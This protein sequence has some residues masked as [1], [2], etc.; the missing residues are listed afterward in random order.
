MRKGIIG[1]MVTV[2]VVMLIVGAVWVKSAEAQPVVL[3]FATVEPPKSFN[4]QKVWGPI[5]EK[6]NKEAEGVFKIEIFA[7]GTLGRNPM[8][9]MK[10]L[11]D[12]VT[13]L[14][15][16]INAYLPGQ[17]V[18]DQV[19]NTPFMAKNCLDCTMS[20]HYM[21]EK[22]MLRGYDD[23]VILG[24]ICL[25]Q[26][27]IHTKFPVKVPAD[28]KGKKMRTAGKI[29]HALAN[30]CGA[31]PVAMPITKVAE[32]ISRGVI[33]GTFSD[34]NAM[35]TFRINDVATYHCLVPF[36]STTLMVAMTKKK[37]ESLP[38]KGKAVIDKY[39]GGYFSRYW[40]ETLDEH[41]VSIETKTTKDPKHTVYKPNAEEMKQWQAVMDPV[42]SSW[43]NEHDNWDNLLKAY[44]DGLGK[45]NSLK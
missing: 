13:D 34:W 35:Q 22:K 32:S 40:A 30:A 38:P 18:D 19:A 43:R 17:L 36:G 8:Q 29:H 9:A 6:M 39:R 33:V 4:N 3:K 5:F 45:A 1:F 24:Q 27:G 15:H 42:I 11:M 25:D 21:Q 44:K 7:G 14:V 12:G 23:L 28:L 16:G 26:Y 20:F 37:Y 31:T 2:T 41:M 10:I